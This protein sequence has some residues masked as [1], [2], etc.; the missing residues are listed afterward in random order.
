MTKNN[1][2]ERLMSAKVKA[3]SDDAARRNYQSFINAMRSEGWTESDINEYADN[4][5]V[6]MGSDDDKAMALFPH[7]LYANADEARNMAK[8]CWKGYAA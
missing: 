3:D 5:K 8:E 4:I 7:G 6:L 1:P 2:L